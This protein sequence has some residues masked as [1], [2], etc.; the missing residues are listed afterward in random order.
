MFK[1]DKQFREFD[2]QYRQWYDEFEKEDGLKQGAQVRYIGIDENDA[3]LKYR[4]YCGHPSDPR[5]ILDLNAI[6]EVEYRILARSW[7]L[8]RLVGFQ[9]DV[10]FSPSIFEVIDK[11]AEG[12]PLKVG[13]RVRYIGG[14]DDLLISGNIYEVEGL[15]MHYHGWYGFVGVKLIGIE[16]IYERG[17][18]DRV[19]RIT[20]QK[21][22][23]IFGK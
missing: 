8:V 22:L 14:E 20:S 11:N 16:K 10:R 4:H 17:L 2:E 1:N 13:G 7:Q 15:M 18:F 23:R 3:C 9:D 5:G 6:Y 21:K 12:K 19:V